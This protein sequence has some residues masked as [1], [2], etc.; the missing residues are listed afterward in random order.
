[1]LEVVNRPWGTFHLYAHNEPCTVKTLFIKAGESLSLQYHNLRSQQYIIADPFL[2]EMSTKP[3]PEYLT[4]RDE[5]MA[6]YQDNRIERHVDAGKEIMIERRVIHRIRNVSG[7]TCMFFEI[8][9]GL[10]DE[11][12]IIR[13]DDK[14]GRTNL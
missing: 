4:N 5:V 11:E 8:A 1:M 9:F 13:L 3:V 7:W 6:W 12:D 10:N 14:Y 2:F